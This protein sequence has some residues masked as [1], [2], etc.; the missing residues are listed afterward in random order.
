MST[1]FSG[2]GSGSPRLYCLVHFSLS[3]G[4]LKDRASALQSHFL[5]LLS[6]FWRICVSRSSSVWQSLSVP[7]LCVR[8]RKQ[9]FLT[10]L[11]LLS[12]M[13]EKWGSENLNY[14]PMIIRMVEVGFKTKKCAIYSRDFLGDLVAKTLCSQCRGPRFDPWSGN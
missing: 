14:L 11:F 9:A 12:L 1:V 2:R 4:I 5:W 13:W 6:E 10:L 3:L 8:W 7:R